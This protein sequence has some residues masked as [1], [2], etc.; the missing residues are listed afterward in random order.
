M[1][2]S[3]EKGAAGERELANILKAHGFD[4]RRG[5]QHSGSPDSPD[6]I[7]IPGVH[8]EVKRVEEFGQGKLYK[9]MAQ[10][11]RDAGEGELVAVFH[12]RNRKRWMVT[13]RYADWLDMAARAGGCEARHVVKKRMNVDREMESLPDGANVLASTDGERAPLAT[14]Y[15]EDWLDIFFKP[16]TCD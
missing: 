12:R 15:L 7:G 10:S 11:A 14:M 6:V 8:I 9:A 1:V 3:R 4:A 5:Q 13:T 2:N 16:L